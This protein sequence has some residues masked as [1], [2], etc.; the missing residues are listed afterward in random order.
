MDVNG[1]VKE[2]KMAIYDISM[3]IHEN[4][5]VYKNKVEKKPHRK[6]ILKHDEVG[7]N[8]SRMFIDLHTGTH[9]DAPFHMLADGYTIEKMDIRKLMRKVSVVDLTEVTERI[10]EK[11]LI[12]KAIPEN[13]FILLKTKNSFTDKFSNEFVFLEKTGA[14]YLRSKSIQGVGIDSLGIERS[15]PGHPTHTILMESG[16][17]IIEGLR[18]KDISEGEYFMY[19]L[20]LKIRGGDGAPARVVLEDL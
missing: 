20:P 6:I 1:G 15:Q 3:E 18:L 5:M 17:I 4:M 8:E 19:A 9:I 14:E 10:E 16:C 11:D 7:I 12:N 13:S 2:K